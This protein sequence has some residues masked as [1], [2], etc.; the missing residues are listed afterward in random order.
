LESLNEIKESGVSVKPR[1]LKHV[2]DE[3]TPLRMLS[4][5]LGPSCRDLPPSPIQA[6][7]INY[8][9]IFVV[10]KDVWDK[11]NYT[12]YMKAKIKC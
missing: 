10:S 5:G 2:A 11:A 8:G 12:E 4:F 6:V 1:S 9:S 3:N 7:T